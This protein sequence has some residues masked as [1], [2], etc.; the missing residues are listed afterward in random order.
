MSTPGIIHENAR[1]PRT[2][3]LTLAMMRPVA[4]R[5]SRDP[6][7]C[8]IVSLNEAAWIELGL[9]LAKEAKPKRRRKR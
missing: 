3:K 4:L 1:A 2:G 6:V 5:M 8:R 9:R 7:A